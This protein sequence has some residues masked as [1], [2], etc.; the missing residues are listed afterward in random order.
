MVSRAGAAYP[1]SFDRLLEPVSDLAKRIPGQHQTEGNTGPQ[2]AFKDHTHLFPEQGLLVNQLYG[3][4][5][6][7]VKL[8]CCGHTGREVHG[9]WRARIKPFIA[10]S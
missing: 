2:T 10:R 9:G 1:P 4:I 3:F 5:L 7:P 6:A 8:G